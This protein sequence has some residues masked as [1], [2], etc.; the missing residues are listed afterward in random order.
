MNLKKD[1]KM[2]NTKIVVLL[3]DFINFVQQNPE[4]LDTFTAII[5][6]LSDYTFNNLVI[7][8]RDVHKIS[9]LED[10]EILTIEFNSINE[11]IFTF[12][13]DA[14]CHFDE[15]Y[16]FER[17]VNSYFFDLFASTNDQIRR[18]L[19]IEAR[20]D[21]LFDDVLDQNKK[22]IDAIYD[23]EVVDEYQIVSFNSIDY[24]LSKDMFIPVN[25]YFGIYI[26]DV[27]PLKIR[28]F[29]DAYFKAFFEDTDTEEKNVY[30][31]S[32]TELQ[33]YLDEYSNNPITLTEYKIL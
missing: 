28:I 9:I 12:T 2:Y 22:V 16:D 26:I 31:T 27:E 17:I 20:F 18:A 7:K 25:K 4:F 30:L 33:D 14:V 6:D 1:P 32:L 13:V 8:R 5:K 11:V 24:I 15:R 3:H 21:R 23:P 19:N 29:G 10:E